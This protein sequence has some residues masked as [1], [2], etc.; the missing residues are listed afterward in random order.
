MSSK[1]VLLEDHKL[2]FN[3]GEKINLHSEQD[4]FDSA[5]QLPKL[6]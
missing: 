2:E 5:K 6:R 3:D 4:E 1:K